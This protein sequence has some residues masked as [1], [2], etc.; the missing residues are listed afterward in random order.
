MAKQVPTSVKKVLVI[1][2]SSIGDIVLTSPVVRA[3]KKQLGA[4]VHFLTK[5]AYFPVVEANPYLDKVHVLEGN[6][7][8][9][10]HS[11]RKEQFDLIVDLHRNLR[12]W[13]FKL[14]LRRKSV[15]FDKINW[16]KWL[17]VTFRINRLP[18]CHIVDRYMDTLMAFGVKNDG[19]GLDYFIPPGEEVDPGDWL[20]G[21]PLPYIA[22]VIGAAHATKRLPDK[23]LIAICQGLDLPVF[24]LGGP[25]DAETG[26]RVARAA[27]PNVINTC[28]ALSLHQ[29]ASLIRQAF[30]VISHDT[31]LMHIAAAFNRD[32]ISV[33]GNTIPAFGMYPYLPDEKEKGHWM[34]VKGLACRPCS[35]IGYKK[36]PKGHFKCMNDQ[37]EKQIVQLAMEHRPE[38]PIN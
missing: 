25:L 18:K 33:W 23:K 27:G 20:S 2:F 36:C 37:D 1:R 34:E 21:G 28:G 12:T 32:V 14:A 10:I 3:L 38:P 7:K 24:L 29:S 4:E 16:E 17:M 5:K 30:K 15:S 35:K 19:E 26:E 6:A 8:D 22:L 31:G 13:R 11:L 9:L